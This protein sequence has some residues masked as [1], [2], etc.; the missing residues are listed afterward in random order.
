[1][2]ECFGGGHSRELI[3][4]FDSCR[5]EPDVCRGNSGQPHLSNSL[6]LKPEF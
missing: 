4:F 3:D 5:I 6:K 2:F 1:M